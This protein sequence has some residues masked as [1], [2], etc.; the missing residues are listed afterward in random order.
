MCPAHRS[1]VLEDI[2]GQLREGAPCLTVSTQLVEA[3][4][5]VSFPR[6][7]RELAGLDSLVQAAGR[8]NREGECD[9]LAP[10]HRIHAG[11]RR[12]QGLPLR[13]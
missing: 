4:V 13:G 7:F 11:R 8:C 5:D 9:G 6:V 12:A 10:G 1:R 2:R 3:G